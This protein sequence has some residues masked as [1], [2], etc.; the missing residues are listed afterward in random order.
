MVDFIFI[1]RMIYLQRVAIYCRLSDEDR[2]KKNIMDESESIHNQ[3][4]MLVNYCLERNWTPYKIYCDED[5]SGADKNRPQF[6]EMINDCENGNVNIVLCKSQSRFSRDMEI[7]ERYLHNKFTEWGVRF[8]SIIDNADTELPGNKKSRQINGLINEW[9]LEDLSHNIKRTLRSKNIMGKF[10]GSFA[11]YGYKIDPNDKNHLIVDPVASEIVKQ[12][13][14]MYING[15]GY[16]KIARELNQLGILNPTSYKKQQGSKYFNAHDLSSRGNLWS[17]STIYKILRKEV[18]LGVLVQGVTENISYKSKKR[19]YLPENKWIKCPNAHDPI[20]SK[21]IWDKAIEIR[22]KR[23]RC[24]K[25]SGEIY[26]LSGKT[27][28]NECGSRMWKMSYKLS[29]GR[30]KYLRC[31]TVKISNSAC[32]N[33]SGIR[34][35][36]VERLIL[37]EI[38]NLLLKFFKPQNIKMDTGGKNEDTFKK[39]RMEISKL[40]KLKEKKYSHLLKLYEDKLDNIISEEQYNIFSKKLEEEARE[41]TKQIT[42]VHSLLTPFINKENDKDAKNLIF[43]KYKCI[44]NLNKVI[45]DELISSIYIGKVNDNGKREIKINWKI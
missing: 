21:E 43:K 1:R 24:D 5:Y 14:N 3:K 7:V 12:I 6:K 22:N 19:R 13:F 31:K 16:I 9:Y 20:I 30:Y 28:C 41:Y 33:T 42:L 40:S 38:N 44:N 2:N 36:K 15:M 39:L 29:Q 26:S 4:N 8:I 17:D 37:D 35:D 10:T 27:F 32:P 11:P 18:Y 23:G 45:V 34:L 25:L